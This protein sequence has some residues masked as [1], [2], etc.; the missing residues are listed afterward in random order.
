MYIGKGARAGRGSFARYSL[1]LLDHTS[2][3]EIKVRS[4]R[5]KNRTE[6]TKYPLTVQELLGH[7]DLK[8]TEI[9]N[10]VVGSRFSNTL[11]PVARKV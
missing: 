9:Y 8:T 2:S 6:K 10:H 11:S 1:R 4:S 7:T 5:T 3:A